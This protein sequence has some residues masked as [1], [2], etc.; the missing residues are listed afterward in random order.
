MIIET[1]NNNGWELREPRV[2]EIYRI[3]YETGHTAVMTYNGVVT[4]ITSDTSDSLAQI[5]ITDVVGAST[6]N[7]DFTKITAK[8]GNTLTIQ[9]TLAVPDR[10]FITPIQKQNISTGEISTL[11]VDTQVVDGAFSV[12]LSVPVGKYLVTQELMNAELP[13]PAFSLEPIEIYITI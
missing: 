2:G 3:T 1:K 9:G 6:T 4:S 12:E 5:I 13:Q 11:Y 10:A 7:S 8:E